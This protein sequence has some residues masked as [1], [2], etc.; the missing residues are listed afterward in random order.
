MKQVIVA[1]LAAL[2]WNG[3]RAAGSFVQVTP[4]LVEIALVPGKSYSGILS[5]CNT[6]SERFTVQVE[7]SEGWVTETGRPGLPTE[8]WLTLRVPA[9]FTLNPGQTRRIRYRAKAPKDFVGETLAHVF[10]S[11]PA[12]GVPS[13][14]LNVQLRRS[15]G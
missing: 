9:T 5:V 6:K 12:E 10:F 3:A 4:S 14:A 13:Q 1:A 15:A 7:V 2:L 8:R 11:F